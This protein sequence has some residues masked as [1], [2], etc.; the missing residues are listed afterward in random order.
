MS[1]QNKLSTSRLK[2]STSRYGLT[3]T[4]LPL[5]RSVQM[6]CKM[7][8]EEMVRRHLFDPGRRAVTGRES[9]RNYVRGRKDEQIDVEMSSLFHLTERHCKGKCKKKVHSLGRQSRWG[10]YVSVVLKWVFML[11]GEILALPSLSLAKT[12]VIAD[13]VVRFP[14]FIWKTTRD[15]FLLIFFS[16]L[17]SDILFI[18]RLPS[19]LHTLLIPKFRTNGGLKWSSTRDSGVLFQAGRDSNDGFR[20][21]HI[22]FGMMMSRWRGMISPCKTH[23]IGLSW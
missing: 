17:E 12:R 20:S 8:Q 5:P 15:L 7:W 14:R 23:C 4:H 18:L 16:S 1:W 9:A 21:M 3:W 2:K 6:Y 10:A 13:E 22:L 11:N 19:I